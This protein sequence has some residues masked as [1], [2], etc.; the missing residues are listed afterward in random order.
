MPSLDQEVRNVQNPAFCAAILGSFIQ[1]F[2]EADLSKQGAPLAYAFLVLPMILHSD[3]YRLLQTT[4]PSL[5]HM[6]EKF[7]SAEYWSTDL[8]LSLNNRALHL[9]RLTADSLAILF[10]TGFAKMD[11]A[12]ARII[13]QRERQFAGRPDIPNEADESRKLGKWMAQLS[14]FEINSILKVSF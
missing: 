7:L 14:P 10:R 1:G 13:P 6:A 8:L 12:K 2:Y 11:P 9:R 3:T 4:K 5:R